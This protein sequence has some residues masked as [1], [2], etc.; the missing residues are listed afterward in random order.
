MLVIWPDQHDKNVLQGRYYA[1]FVL[2]TLS[3]TSSGEP[4]EAE[5]RMLDYAFG[6]PPK[7]PKTASPVLRGV[8]KAACVWKSPQLWCRAMNVCDG[9]ATVEK[10]GKELYLEALLCLDPGVVVP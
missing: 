1:R 7:D 2:R 3:E 6:L 9:S 4:T 5:Q 10:L 8:C